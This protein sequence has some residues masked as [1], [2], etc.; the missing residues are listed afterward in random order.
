MPVELQVAYERRNSF[1]AD[2]TR[3]IA[4]GGT[5]IPTTRTVEI[6]TVFHFRLLV[7]GRAAPFD[8]E[9]V[10]VENGRADG[11]P[12]IAIRFRWHDEDSRRRF[13]EA[14]RA[15]LE[16]S[17]GP[18]LARRLLARGAGRGH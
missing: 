9:G 14:V 2:Y 4:R 15:M 5:F 7:P 12:G 1:F 11:K 6:G 17:F 16:E 8:L 3:N 13:E 18:E 10:V